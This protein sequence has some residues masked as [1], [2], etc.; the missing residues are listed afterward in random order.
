ML[1][2]KKNVTLHNYPKPMYS[3]LKKNTV[4]QLWPLMAIVRVLRQKMTHKR[5]GLSKQSLTVHLEE[6]MMFT[7]KQR[8]QRKILKDGR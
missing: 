8:K 6:E 4:K 7:R 3:L 1:Q 2:W 5:R